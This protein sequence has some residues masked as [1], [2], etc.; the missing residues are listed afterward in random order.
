MLLQCDVSQSDMNV[1]LLVDFSTT[2]FLC[3]CVGRR[4][5]ASVVKSNPFSLLEPFHK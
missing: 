5:L 4:S 3:K 2:T 1:C